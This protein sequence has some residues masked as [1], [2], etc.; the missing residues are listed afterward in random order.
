MIGVAACSESAPVTAPAAPTFAKSS[1]ALPPG[2]HW[3]SDP[4]FFG[5]TVED[6]YAAVN[7]RIEGL[8]NAKVSALVVEGEVSVLALVTCIKTIKGRG[9][10]TQQRT[11]FERRMAIKGSGQFPIAR[12]GRV[13]GPLYI[14]HGNGNQQAIEFCKSDNFD[15]GE[16]TALRGLGNQGNWLLAPS[17][18]GLRNITL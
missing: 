11:V 10:S 6:G 13:V 8:G 12:N 18:V 5:V 1:T 16:V 3:A 7:F 4:S 14:Y 17:P 9:Q 15:T 2:A